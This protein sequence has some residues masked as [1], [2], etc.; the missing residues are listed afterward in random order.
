MV[1]IRLFHLVVLTPDTFPTFSSFTAKCLWILLPVIPCQ[2]KEKQWPII[3]Y[4]IFG[5]VKFIL[6]R[7]LH[8]W[9]LICESNDSYMRVFIYFLSILTFSYVVD[10]ETVFV[11]IITRDKYTL[12]SLNNFPFFSQSLREFWGRRYNR[13]IS[14]IF[15]E[16][17]FRP[18]SL[19][20]PSRSIVS[21]LIFIIS[22]L[23]HVHIVFIVFNEPSSALPTFACF[24]L[25]GIACCIEAHLA[26]K[27]PPLL[28]WLV[29]HSVLFVTAPMCLGTFARDKSVFFGLDGLSTYGDQWIS[30]LPMPKSCPK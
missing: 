30:K 9:L 14:T 2:S 11:R 29:T 25:N 13:I 28:G 16:S 18:L 26:I 17:I 6:N 22:G 20:I 24:F 12:Q 8:R 5:V 3:F 21:L 1:S 27:L 23:F 15:N 7:W 19:F 4:L 10:I